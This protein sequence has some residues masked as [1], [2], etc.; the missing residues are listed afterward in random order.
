MEQMMRDCRKKKG[1]FEERL[2]RDIKGSGRKGQ[3][4]KREVIIEE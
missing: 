4:A 3:V 1:T 2:L